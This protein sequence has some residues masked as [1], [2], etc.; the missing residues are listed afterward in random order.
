MTCGFHHLQSIFQCAPQLKY[1]NI[2]LATT[3]MYSTNHTQK[4][5]TTSI[6][7][8]PTLHTLIIAFEKDDLT[9]FDQSAQYLKVMPALC[10]LEI[11]ACGALLDASA[12]EALSQTS[13]SSLTHFNLQITISRMKKD[14]IETVLASFETP[15]WISKENFYV[16]ISKH[17]PLGY[18]RFGMDEAQTNQ[19]NEFSQPVAQW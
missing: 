16:M 13:L 2:Q 5:P 7:S 1:L 12:W 6:K 10:R 8:I 15:F 3:V 14:G 9:T 4:S 17:A 19:Q 18:N 11:K